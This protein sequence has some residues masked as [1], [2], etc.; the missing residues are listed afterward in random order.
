LLDVL[1]V[2]AGDAT[3]EES[4]GD[5]E[6]PALATNMSTCAIPAIR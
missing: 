6:H 4:T 5:D 3:P 2:E 1:V